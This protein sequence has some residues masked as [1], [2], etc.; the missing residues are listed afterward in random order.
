MIT[1][2]NSKAIASHGPRVKHRNV[3]RRSKS[4]WRVDKAI[5]YRV[6]VLSLVDV[7]MS[8]VDEKMRSKT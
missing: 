6:Y 7:G 1:V 5:L 4:P 8:I 2:T 3:E